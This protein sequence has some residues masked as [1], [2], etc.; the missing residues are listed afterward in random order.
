MEKKVFVSAVS[1]EFDSLRREIAGTL[2]QLGFAVC[3]QDCFN[4][5]PQ[6][7]ILLEE[8]DDYV[9][10]CDLGIFI[11]GQA[12]GSEPSENAIKPF[13]KKGYLPPGW[14][15]ATYTQWEFLL[16]S[17]PSLL[18][19]DAESRRPRLPYMVF[20]SEEN[21]IT[22]GFEKDT[23]GE[24]QLRFREWI[25]QTGIR[26]EKFRNTD[27]VVKRLLQNPNFNNISSPRPIRLPSMSLKGCFVGRRQI[28]EN[29]IHGPY[30]EFLT[31]R[32]ATGRCQVNLHCCAITGLA[33]IGKS[34][35][36][37][38]YGHR[39]REHFSAVLYVS[40]SSIDTF[41]SEFASLT[42]SLGVGQS[43]AIPDD[44]KIR[45]VTQRLLS[46][47]LH[48]WLLIV[49]N[50]DDED[51]AVGVWKL[52]ANLNNGFILATGRDPRIFEP[53]FRCV[54]LP[55][56]SPEHGAELIISR[57]Y[58]TISS[59]PPDDIAAAHW[60][61][62]ELEGH[63]FALN[64]VAAYV[65]DDCSI[66]EYKRRW[67]T[68]RDDFGF[69]VNP[70]IEISKQSL[71]TLQASLNRLRRDSIAILHLI[72]ACTG[73]PIPM[74]LISSLTDDLV[75]G[76]ASTLKT[77]EQHIDRGAAIRELLRYKMIV[78]TP[79][80]VSMHRVV[81][82]ALVNSISDLEQQACRS[83]AVQWV[84]ESLPAA[85][86]DSNVELMEQ[87]A[88]HLQFF[89]EH[90]DCIPTYLHKYHTERGEK[91]K[92]EGSKLVIR[93]RQNI[94]AGDTSNVDDEA[95]LL[96]KLIVDL[97]RLV[98]E[99]NQIKSDYLQVYS[100]YDLES[101]E[102]AQAEQHINAVIPG[103]EHFR[104]AQSS[105][106]LDLAW[107]EWRRRTN[108]SD[109]V[110]H[111]L[112]RDAFRYLGID[113]VEVLLDPIALGAKSRQTFDDVWKKKSNEKAITQW[114]TLA[115]LVDIEGYLKMQHYVYTANGQPDLADACDDVLLHLGVDVTRNTG[116]TEQFDDV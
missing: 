46:D 94:C 113:D 30:Y 107:I 58:K 17:M 88:L 73:E 106:A 78:E 102:R 55:P 47:E 91:L 77:E 59:A 87:F 74:L 42:G 100:G 10:E 56:L 51:T 89:R 68:L 8:I 13:L 86:S 95:A 18:A 34:Q 67:T 70:A 65:K 29:E 25:T 69:P 28:L 79:T 98:V 24:L 72:A 2:G 44:E 97:E 84:N 101:D 112:L 108:S 111:Q 31:N 40:A 62:K 96:R 36:A 15:N 43:D 38:E 50:V 116:N 71:I 37:I 48:D 82:L 14:N 85:T 61:S 45:S 90:D 39:Y 81:R 27:Y 105:A 76:I 54:G 66:C 41:K 12:G 11:V 6:K 64:L 3:Y 35:I 110:P 1:V 26:R 23:N 63:P 103:D 80:S 99:A 109:R 21:P 19:T 92:N 83:V 52:L 22:A 4:A 115:D 32:H 33:G 57:R 93:C 75:S 104:V 60:L 114:E 5:N 9:E 16:S 20:L 7:P 49:D 53:P